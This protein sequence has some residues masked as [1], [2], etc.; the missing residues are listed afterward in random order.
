MKGH[1]L[2][3]VKMPKRGQGIGVEAECECGVKLRARNSTRR[4]AIEEAHALHLANVRAQS[5]PPGPG[6]PS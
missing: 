5:G 2:R 3:N 1:A 6:E 4:R